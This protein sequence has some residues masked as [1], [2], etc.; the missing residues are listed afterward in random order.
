MPVLNLR[1]KLD[2]L[3]RELE[4]SQRQ[5]LAERTA[6]AEAR[7]HLEA[8]R[9]AQ[10]VL[11]RVAQAVQELAH[12]KLAAVAGR[13]LKAVF[14]HDPYGFRFAFERKRGRTE[15]RPL[16]TRGGHELAPRDVGGGTKEVTA[17]ALRLGVL[18]LSRPRPRAFVALDEPFTAVRGHAQARVRQL[19]LALADELGFQI[20]LVPHEDGFTAGKVIRIG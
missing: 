6:L 2:H 18:T 11:Q 16:F 9:E 20:V 3:R 8:A 17:L 14:P 19:L 13:C 1:T 15:A 5:A 12:H 7:R 10:A 4:L